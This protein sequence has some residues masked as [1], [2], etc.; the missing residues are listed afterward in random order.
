MILFA[1][2]PA[3]TRL[4]CGSSLQPSFSFADIIH[5]VGPIAQGQPSATQKAELGNCYTNS[6]KLATENK[7]RTVVSGRKSTIS[8]GLP[9]A[10]FQLERDC[11]KSP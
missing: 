9:S 8:Q 6:L 2:E 3:Q 1:M 5:T 7:L 10:S 4:C 11:W